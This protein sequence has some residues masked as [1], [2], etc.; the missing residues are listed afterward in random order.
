M[1]HVANEDLSAHM[2][3]EHSPGSRHIADACER[4]SLR[5]THEACILVPSQPMKPLQGHQAISSLR[6]VLLRIHNAILL[7]L[8][9]VVAVHRR[10]ELENGR[11]ASASE[12]LDNVCND[13]L[14]I[15]LSPLG[16]KS[17]S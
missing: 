4:S 2:H 8:R 16:R 7:D 3:P 10:H 14:A 17:C 15:I 11:G 13:E 1:A 9:L 5:L 6:L 12:A